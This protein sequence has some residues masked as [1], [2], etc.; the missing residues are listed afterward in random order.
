MTAPAFDL[1]ERV[2]IV[3][4]AT[5]GLGR[6]I[7][8]GLAAAGAHVVVVARDPDAC[9]RTADELSASGPRAHPLAADVAD[10][11]AAPALIEAAAAAFGRLDLLVNNAGMSPVLRRLTDLDEAGFDQI[12]DVNVKSVWRLSTLAAERMLA[13]AGGGILNIS[14]TASVL[15]SAPV[16][17]YAAAKGAVNVLTRALA[18]AY[19]P[20]IRVNAIL[21]GTFRTDLT[22][23]FVDHPAFVKRIEAVSPLKRV[24]DPAEV[25]GAALYFASDLSSYASGSLLQLD[26]GE[27]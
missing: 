13:G 6:A 19:G 10:W 18:R 23:G 2:A 11:A 12:F 17:P 24:G 1:S 14:S 26:G 5:R 15:G 21:C 27:A 8:G 22:A 4:G 7:A 25:V 16:A 20:K 3:T 9:R